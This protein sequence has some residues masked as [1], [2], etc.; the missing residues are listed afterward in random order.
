MSWALLLSD[1]PRSI[2]S[3]DFYIS[4]LAFLERQGWASEELIA[5]KLRDD[6]RRVAAA[7][8]ELHRNQLIDIAGHFIRVNA[9]GKVLLDRF[10]LDREVVDD[11]LDAL[12]LEGKE[13]TGYRSVLSA[14]RNHAFP[15]YLNSICTIRT[16]SDFEK[17]AGVEDALISSEQ[18]LRTGMLTLLIRDLREWYSHN[19]SVRVVQPSSADSGIDYIVQGVGSTTAV[20]V[21]YFP[22]STRAFKWLKHLDISE[23]RSETAPERG[24]QE[25]WLEFR[26]LRSLTLFDEF[27]RHSAGGT[28]LSAWET[29]LS[30]E[31]RSY[32]NM[33][34]VLEGLTGESNRVD[35]LVS[36]I[37]LFPAIATHGAGARLWD[38]NLLALLLGAPTL[39]EFAEM[40]GESSEGARLLLTTI[41]TKCEDLLSTLQDESRPPVDE[42]EDET[43]R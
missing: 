28:W 18:A 43:A 5:E 25:H 15:N 9:L 22:E 34:L 41:K 23:R 7:L 32:T 12:S 13:R 31:D 36:N 35:A 10:E 30:T 37:D 3:N 42:I 21:K 6:Q 17:S 1:Y 20:Q 29:M 2:L 11:V 14:Y 26:T 8:V 33:L 4:V 27:Q 40:A 24:L 19:P 39:R 16:W 38:V